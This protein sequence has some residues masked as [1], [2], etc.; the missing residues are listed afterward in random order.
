M[1][2]VW[3]SCL[4][5]NLRARLRLFCFPFAGGSHASFRLWPDMLPPDVEVCPVHLPGR[6]DRLQ[7]SP[8]T[9]LAPLVEMLADA[10]LPHLNKPFAFF[11]HSMGAL[12]SFELVRQLRR[13]SASLPLYMFVS[14]CPAPQVYTTEVPTYNLPDSA[15][16]EELRRLNGTPQQVIEHPEILELMLPTLRADFAVCE[17]YTYSIEPPLDCPIAAFGGLNDQEVSREEL[18]A[19]RRQTT[20]LFTLRMFPGDHFYCQTTAPTL[21]KVLSEKLERREDK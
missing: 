5:P 10:L 16:I 12:M 19:W 3:I 17:T 18:E 15:F 21:L 9:R 8:F 6:G 2:A 1:S 11:G 20:A 4:K 13:R 14:A 7:E